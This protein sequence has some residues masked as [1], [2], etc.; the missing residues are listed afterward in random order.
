MIKRVLLGIGGTPFTK[1][2]IRRA[3]ELCQTHGAQ[4]TAVTVIDEKRLR[5]VGSVPMGA[6][7]VAQEWRDQRIEEAYKQVEECVEELKESCE[8]AKV[9][10]TI[11]YEEGQPFQLMIEHAR[12]HDISV[13]GLRSM[14]EYDILHGTGAKP[15]NIIDRMTSH[16]VKPIIASS[17]NFKPIRKAL[18]AYGGSIRAAASMHLFIQMKLWPDMEIRLIDCSNDEGLAHRYLSDAKAY[19]RAHGYEPEVVHRQGNP[20]KEILAEAG[21]WDADI[22]V[23]GTS[24]ESLITKTIFG[25]TAKH[26]IQKADCPLFIGK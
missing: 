13:F 2:A 25:S 26:I 4:L 24:C 21:E 7:G 11:L 9:H 10:L 18:I 14:F 20:T 15:A 3:I 19:V 12:Y 17:E 22:I 23:L 5:N 1:V 16:G 8:K 6:S